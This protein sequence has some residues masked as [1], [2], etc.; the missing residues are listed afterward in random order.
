MKPIRMIKK[1][2]KQIYVSPRLEVWLYDVETVLGNTLSIIGE[3]EPG[4][5]LGKENNIVF[6]DLPDDEFTWGNLWADVEDNE[7]E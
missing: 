4:V 5:D 1:M 6:S 2:R 7:E 3:D